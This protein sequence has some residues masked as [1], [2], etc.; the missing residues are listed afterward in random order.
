MTNPLR[1]KYYD[2]VLTGIMQ[3]LQLLGRKDIFELIEMELPY[4]DELN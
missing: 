2:G 4:H 1:A 3:S